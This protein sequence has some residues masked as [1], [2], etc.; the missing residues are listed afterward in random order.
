MDFCCSITRFHNAICQRHTRDGLV[1]V[2]P[3]F[4]FSVLWY[5]LSYSYLTI[6]LSYGLHYL[7]SVLW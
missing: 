1:L 6:G 5:L 3:H 2:L 4:L 7:F